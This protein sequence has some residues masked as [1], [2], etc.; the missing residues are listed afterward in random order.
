MLRHVLLAGL[1][2]APAAAAPPT[3]DA[4]LLDRIDWGII[5]AGRS[6]RQEVAP[7]TM[8]G[9]IDLYE[10]E[11]G[12]GLRTQTLPALPELAFGVVAW[13][14]TDLDDVTITVT[15]PPMAPAGTTRQS[16]VATFAAGQGAANFFRFDLPEERVPGLWR[17]VAT[18]GDRIVYEASFEV[19]DPALMPAFTDPCPGPVPVS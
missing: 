17:F 8:L 14:V 12:V 10:G 15:H 4:A 1:L 5:C 16:W 19:V 11:A 9:F 7:D 2:A 18:Q 13:A 3:H 6:G